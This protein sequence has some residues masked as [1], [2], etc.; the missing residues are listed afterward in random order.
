[1]AEI[2]PRK[3]PSSAAYSGVVTG[4]HSFLKIVTRA[5]TK[6]PIAP[7]IGKMPPAAWAARA[8][9]QV[10]A[11]QATRMSRERPVLLTVP[12]SVIASAPNS[13]GRLRDVVSERAGS[14]VLMFSILSQLHAAEHEE[15]ERPAAVVGLEELRDE[16]DAGGEAD[17]RGEG[18]A[19]GGVP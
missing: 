5:T 14:P 10:K 11:A 12:C 16:V 7:P 18:G 4:A 3:R 6:P 17:A 19:G 13:R 1:M 2:A 15:G 9:C 8:W